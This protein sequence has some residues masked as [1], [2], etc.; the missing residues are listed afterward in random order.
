MAYR[1]MI[2]D[3]IADCKRAKEDGINHSEI[4]STILPER[5]QSFLKISTDFLDWI[6]DDW[7]FSFYFYEAQQSGMCSKPNEIVASIIDTIVFDEIED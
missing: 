4:R 5:L 3:L 7:E 1:Q 2:S 6:R